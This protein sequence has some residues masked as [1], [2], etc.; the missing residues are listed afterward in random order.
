MKIDAEAAGPQWAR[1]K[2]P[3]VIFGGGVLRK[4]RIDE[5][6]QLFNILR[7]E[8]SFVGPRPERPEFEDRLSVE[9]PY[10]RD[11]L[12]VAPGLTGW[13]QVRHPYGASVEDARRKLEY[14][15]YYMKH[16]TVTMDLFILLDTARIVL[17]G[18]VVQNDRTERCMKELVTSARDRGKRDEL[19]VATTELG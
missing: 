9:I 8:M 6:P 4:F 7:G 17:G 12:L 1:Q 10:F 3:R 15:L 5:I 19:A 18:G 2:D 11:R 16:M 13:A 14:D